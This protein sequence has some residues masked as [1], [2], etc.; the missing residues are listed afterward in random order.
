M[1]RLS[2]LSGLVLV[3]AGYASLRANQL[4]FTSTA[5]FFA[6]DSQ[7]ISRAPVRATKASG[8]YGV[9]EWDAKD[10]ENYRYM[11]DPADPGTISRD[12][13]VTDVRDLNELLKLRNPMSPT[14]DILLVGI[15]LDDG[16]RIDRPG[17]EDL[18]KLRPSKLRPIW[19]HWRDKSKI[20]TKAPRDYDEIISRLLNCGP[21][22]LEDMVR[23]NWQTF[24]RGFY[25]RIEELKMDCTEPILKQKIE[26]LENMSLEIIKVAQG[27]MKRTLPQQTKEAQE[28]LSAMLEPD[29]SGVLLWP[30]PPAAYQR[31]AE[32]VTK[33]AI[34]NKYENGWFENVLEVCERFTTKMETQGKAEMVSMGK[35][36]MQ[37]LLTEWLRQDSLWEETD[38]GRF[39][40]KLMSI[41]HEQ[42]PAALQIETAPL[43]ATKLTDELKIISETK[44]MGLPM[45]SKL[46]VYAAK[47]IQ[48]ISEFVSKKDEYL[49]KMGAR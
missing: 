40:Y 1:V 41:S 5:S 32:A 36:T 22:E 49:A 29:G 4:G 26:N 42:W 33:Y 45:G 15:T 24:D 35:A 9:A 44:V 31:L 37:R 39:I 2:P 47:Y 27:Q 46:Q 10:D 11:T 12:V 7:R 3:A 19:F 34:R 30:A 18:K 21:A 43:D 25:F 16:K 38:S 13:K 8:K 23:A 20:Q 28:I 6:K 48:G 17:V 14:D